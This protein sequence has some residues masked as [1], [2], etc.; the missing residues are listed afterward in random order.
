MATETSIT[1]SSR[2]VGR[3]EVMCHLCQGISCI[4][5]ACCFLLYPATSSSIGLPAGW[6][7][8]VVLVEKRCVDMPSVPCSRIKTMPDGKPGPPMQ[9]DTSGCI[10]FCKTPTDSCPMQ[11]LDFCKSPEDF[12]PIATG[13]TIQLCGVAILV[14]NRHVLAETQSGKPLFVRARLRSGEPIRLIVGEMHGHPNPNVDLAACRLRYSKSVK[15]EDIAIGIIPED[16]LRQ[17]GMTTLAPL[18]TVRAGDEAVF[19]G[20]PLV[21]GGVRALVA[22]RETPLIRSGIVS[23]VLPGDIQFGKRTAHDIFLMDSWA[24]QG[25]SG[26]PVVIPPSLFGYQGDDRDRKNAHIVGIV[27]EFLDLNAPIE[28]AVVV[29]GVRAKINSGLAIVQSLDGIESMV[30]LFVGAKCIPIAETKTGE[31]GA[32]H[33][34]KSPVNGK[35]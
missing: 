31:Q 9:D 7:T 1:F 20:F 8:A 17:Q 19:A 21:I 33:K 3:F 10:N 15:L 18:S 32:E 23:I 25:N 28:K 27:S 14:S 4:I 29:G 11:F 16:V 24:F 35:P 34:T 12:C 30:Q 6:D 26:S 13:F 5:V 22:D 2:W